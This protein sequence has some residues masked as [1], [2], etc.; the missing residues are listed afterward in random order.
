M[1]AGRTTVGGGL[2]LTVCL[3]AGCRSDPAAP[4]IVG[5]WQASSGAADE[6]SFQIDGTYELRHDGRTLQSGHYR[7]E[8]LADEKQPYKHKLSKCVRLPDNDCSAGG[9]W[10]SNE[11]VLTGDSFRYEDLGNAV[12]SWRRVSA[13]P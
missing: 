7:L 6:I 2:M 9:L 1:S 5:R 13:D 3:L 10:T 8:P 4:S 11:I 12:P